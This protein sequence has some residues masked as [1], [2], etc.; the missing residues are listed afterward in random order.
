MKWLNV[1]KW[2]TEIYEDIRQ[3]LLVRKALKEPE[4][5]DKFNKFKYELRT[6]KIGRIYTVINVPEELWPYEKKGMVWPW[7]VEQ[8]RELDTLLLELQLSELVYPVVEPIEGAPS[9]LVVL[10]PSTESFTLIKFLTWLFRC[11][12]LTLTYLIT[13]KLIFKLFGVTIFHFLISLFH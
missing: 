3:W 5:I 9:Y 6:D 12:F 11:G 8:L 7:M 13:N 2:P 10:T 1:L 4:T